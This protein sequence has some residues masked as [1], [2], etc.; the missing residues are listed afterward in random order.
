MTYRRAHLAMNIILEIKCGHVEDSYCLLPALIV[1]MMR[2]NPGTYMRVFRARDLRPG[3]DDKFARLFWAFGPSIRSFQRTLRSIVLVDGTHLRGK[4]LGILLIAVGVDGNNGLVPLAFGVVET[5]NEDSWCWFFYLVK[6]HVLQEG[7]GALTLCSDRQKGLMQAVPKARSENAHNWIAAIP[8]ENWASFYFKGDRYD[9]LTTNRSECYNAVLKDARKLPIAATVELTH[10]KSS[11]YIQKRQAMGHE[12][13]TKCTH[14]AEKHLGV[15]REQGRGYDAYRVGVHEFE[16]RSRDH[17][18]VVDLLQQTC[19]CREFQTLGLPC[20]H[21]MAAIAITDFDEYDYCQKW[22]RIE[23]YR[24]TY[25]EVLH[26]T[27]D[28]TQLEVPPEPLNI[29]LP[30]IAKRPPRRPRTRRS[31]RELQSGMHRKCTICEKLGHNKRTCREPPMERQLPDE[32]AIGPSAPVFNRYVIR[33]V[34]L[35]QLLF[36]RNYSANNALEAPLGWMR[37]GLIESV[38][39]CYISARL[40]AWSLHKIPR[41]TM[42]MGQMNGMKILGGGYP[43]S[44]TSVV[45]NCMVA[46]AELEASTCGEITWMGAPSLLVL[47]RKAS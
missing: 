5:E 17:H 35:V 19:T 1:E 45:G 33:R 30:P 10:F 20:R 22:F 34:Y 44:S 12:W 29:V 31:D 23:M 25:A 8:K 37:S 21:A 3:G 18:D 16:V 46:L 26:P 32:S 41:I 28:R 43:D 15:A 39:S 9:V 4:Y 38:H 7:I 2:T 24:E 14:Y 27:V 11:E 42:F 13:E 6:R 47:V 40:Q 36:S